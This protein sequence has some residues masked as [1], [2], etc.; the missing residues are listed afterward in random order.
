MQLSADTVRGH[1]GHR[2]AITIE[3]LCPFTPYR[4]SER[5]RHLFEALKRSCAEKAD[6]RRERDDSYAPAD[7]GLPDA[8]TTWCPR[9]RTT[10][11]SKIAANP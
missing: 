3:R 9:T 7:R 6:D 4:F 11:R 1:S 8:S 5:A 2:L 10:S